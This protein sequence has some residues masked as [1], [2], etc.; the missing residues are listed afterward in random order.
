MDKIV[1]AWMPDRL[2]SIY[3]PLLL[4]T[5]ATWPYQSLR[6]FLRKKSKGASRFSHKSITFPFFSKKNCMLFRKRKTEAKECW[7]LSLLPERKKSSIP[8]CNMIGFWCRS[9]S[10]YFC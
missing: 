7:L 2:N 8:V 3:V 1:Y 10:F 5:R 9:I 6:V 4:L